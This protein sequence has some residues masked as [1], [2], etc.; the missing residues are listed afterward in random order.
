MVV[1]QA[2][3]AGAMLVD[4]LEVSRVY[5]PLGIHRKSTAGRC[6]TSL[7][8]CGWVGSAYFGDLWR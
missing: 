8:I 1:A 4:V 3:L 6:G 5:H 7:I 2:C